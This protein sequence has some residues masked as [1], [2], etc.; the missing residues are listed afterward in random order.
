MHVHIMH[1]I[2]IAGKIGWGKSLADLVNRLR[3]P[4]IQIIIDNLLADL[5][6][7]Q[8]F[9]QMLCQTLSS[10]KYVTLPL[11]GITIVVNSWVLLLLKFKSEN[12]K[13]Q[14]QLCEY[15]L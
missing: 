6:I 13:L 8:V 1:T 14:Y 3:S 2:I 7:C 9:C 4:T 10:P 12:F 5:F 11:L 15:L